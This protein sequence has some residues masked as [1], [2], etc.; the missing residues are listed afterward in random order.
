[1]ADEEPVDTPMEETPEVEAPV[2][3]GE[4]DIMKALQE[5]LK[6]SLVHDGLVRGL[7]ETAKA[8]DRREAQL[9]VLASDCDAKDYTKLIEGLCGEH[10]VS[11]V[12]VP[13]KKQLGEWSGLCKIDAEGV[14]TKVVGCT[15][16]VV[17]DFGEPSR[18]YDFLLEYINESKDDKE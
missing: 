12:R 3:V 13:D 5:V 18:G 11:L 8:L 9:C 7:R 6:K 1:M 4:M 17:K 15:C 10:D 16:V 2:D 14:A